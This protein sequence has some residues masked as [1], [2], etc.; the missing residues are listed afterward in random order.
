MLKGWH[1]F[2]AQTPTLFFAWHDGSRMFRL[3]TGAF[4]DGAL[5]PLWAKLDAR[6]QGD[7][8]SVLTERELEKVHPGLTKLVNFPALVVTPFGVLIGGLSCVGM[9]ESAGYQATEVGALVGCV[10]GG[11]VALCVLWR[12]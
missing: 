1:I 11:L 3:A 9:T 2:K 7:P 10:L 6:P 12:F 8:S 4:P 5:E